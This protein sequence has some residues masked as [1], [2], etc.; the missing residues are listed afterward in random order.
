MHD[1]ME[2]P[3]LAALFILS[4]SIQALHDFQARLSDQDATNSSQVT[5]N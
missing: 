2:L 5:S 1:D 3:K 4:H